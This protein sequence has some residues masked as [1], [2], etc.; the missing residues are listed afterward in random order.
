MDKD[1]SS[2]VKSQAALDQ[3]WR[4]IEALLPRIVEIG[5]KGIATEKDAELANMCVKLVGWEISLR[6]VQR[7]Q[8]I[9]CMIIKGELPNEVGVRLNTIMGH[10]TFYVNAEEIETDSGEAAEDEPVIGRV[11]VRAYPASM[12][13]IFVVI[14][15]TSFQETTFVPASELLQ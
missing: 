7:D 2:I 3:A 9:R 6:V 12:P 4:S 1:Q 13:G 14:M 15:P 11:R 10:Q 5:D 8:F